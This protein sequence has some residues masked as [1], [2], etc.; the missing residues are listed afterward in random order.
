MECG[1]TNTRKTMEQLK[2]RANLAK[3]ED[4]EENV[5]NRIAASRLKPESA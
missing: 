1:F 5:G 3:E 4:I 2:L